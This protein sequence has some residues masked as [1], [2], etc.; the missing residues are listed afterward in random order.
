MGK[1]WAIIGQALAQ[2]AFEQHWSGQKNDWNSIG[3]VFSIKK[4][5]QE[6]LILIEEVLKMMQENRVLKVLQKNV[7]RNFENDVRKFEI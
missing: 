2:H 4:L 7:K 6:V 3:Q 1:N 5:F